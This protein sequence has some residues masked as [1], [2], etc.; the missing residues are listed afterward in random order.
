MGFR[1]WIGVWVMVF[2]F[3]VVAFDLSFLVRYITRFT[4]EA[5]SILISVIFIYEAFSKA[6]ETFFKRPVHYGV[7]RQVPITPWLYQCHCTPVPPT[8]VRNITSTANITAGTEWLV[9]ID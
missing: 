9:S 1:F 7:V 4:E 5:F 8:I 2:L 6:F 3:I